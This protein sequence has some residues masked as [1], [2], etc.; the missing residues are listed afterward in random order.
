MPK[1]IFHPY[2]LDTSALFSYIEDE[3]GADTVEIALM[4]KTTIIPWTVLME[5]YYITLQE[6][7]I[8]EADRRIALMKELNLRIL[9][10]MNESNLLTAARLKAEHKTSFADAIIAAFAIR[11]NCILMHR[12]PEYET[13]RGLVLME[14][15]PY[16]NANNE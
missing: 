4:E 14:V 9:W 11:N 8:A 13:L 6:D 2:L 15:L 3:P 7:G 10:N 5:V 1:E 16:K 12:D